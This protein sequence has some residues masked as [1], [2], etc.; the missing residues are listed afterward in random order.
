VISPNSGKLH[1][2]FGQNVKFEAIFSKLL[3]DLKK[4]NHEIYA[5]FY[6]I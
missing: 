1:E 6:K 4:I 5:E 3:Q 2:Q